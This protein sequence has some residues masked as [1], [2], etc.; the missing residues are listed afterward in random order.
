MITARQRNARYLTKHLQD[1][2]MLSLPKVRKHT[3]HAFMMYPILVAPNVNKWEVMAY[4]EAHEIE[5]REML[6]LTNQPVYEGL[7]DQADYPVADFVNRHGFYIGCHQDL[8][9]DDLSR[10]VEVLRGYCYGNV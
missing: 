5:T 2:G 1:L 7:F 9:Q 4:L 6:P 8:A 3:Q 10:I